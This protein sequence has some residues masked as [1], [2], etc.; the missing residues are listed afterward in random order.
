MDDLNK[1]LGRLCKMSPKHKAMYQEVV[2]KTQATPEQMRIWGEECMKCAR[3]ATADTGECV[4]V[5]CVFFKERIDTE[6]EMMVCAIVG[7]FNDPEAKQAALLKIGETCAERR[8]M[9]IAV[10]LTAEAWHSRAANKYTRA[11]DD[12]E[13]QKVL[14]CM[15]MDN[16]KDLTFASFM[17]I[18]RDSDN[19]IVCGEWQESDNKSKPTLLLQ[20]WIGYLKQGL[21]G[22]EEKVKDAMRRQ[23]EMN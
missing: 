21:S 13:R 20:F 9:P 3:T 4:P 15:G 10:F 19:K 2:D 12:P 5:L 22:L 8:F 16:R 7:D 1:M 18:T 17:P 23:A 6:V 14:V 11:S